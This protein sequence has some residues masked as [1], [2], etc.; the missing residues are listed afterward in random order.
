VLMCAWTTWSATTAALSS[1]STPVVAS[2]WDARCSVVGVGGARELAF[3][4]YISRIW[5][6]WG[7]GMKYIENRTI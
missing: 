1:A 2:T 4:S 3:S 5:G 6:G 7:G